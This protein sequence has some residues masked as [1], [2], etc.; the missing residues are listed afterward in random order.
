[1][2][3]LDV[4]NIV[5][6]LVLVFYLVLVLVWL[7]IAY[8]WRES[9]L[10]ANFASIGGLGVGLFGFVATLYTLFETQRVSRNAQ[11]EIQTATLKAQQEIQRA[12][13][14]AQEAVRNAQ[15]QI[16]QV[17]ERVKH[18]DR[19]ADFATLHMWIRE[20]RTAA[21]RGDWHRALFFAEECPAVVERLRNADGL[22]DDE[23]R[24][25][26]RGRTTSASSRRTFARIA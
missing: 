12:A 5:W 14:E 10:F 4:P 16:R 8:I 13:S 11:Q 2:P 7:V 1:M 20:L 26:A 3:K 6:I 21:G 22:E 23:R 9:S 19:E 18:G 15:E 24:R 17:L 25:S